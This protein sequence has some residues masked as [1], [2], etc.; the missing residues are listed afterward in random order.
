[1]TINNLP[2]EIIRYMVNDFL[3]FETTLYLEQSCKKYYAQGL[4]KEK[5]ES[6]DFLKNYE[7]CQILKKSQMRNVIL[8]AH[9]DNIEND[10]VPNKQIQFI[11][12]H[13]DDTNNTFRIFQILLHFSKYKEKSQFRN[14]ITFR[15]VKFFHKYFKKKWGNSND[16]GIRI[17]FNLVKHRDIYNWEYFCIDLYSIFENINHIFSNNVF[18]LL[19]SND[20]YINNYNI[21][22]SIIFL[23][24]LIFHTRTDTTLPYYSCNILHD[25]LIFESNRLVSCMLLCN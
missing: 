25:Y 21:I 14:F 2:N 15:L 12:L 11:C 8:F 23:N 22:N 24:Y 10:T 13:N 1:M 5:I 20:I 9:I 17:F 19:F 16:A 3:S 18:Y 6:H 7:I 4:L